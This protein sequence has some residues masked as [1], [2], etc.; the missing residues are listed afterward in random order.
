MSNIF[1]KQS[2]INNHP[3]RNNFDLS[4]QNHLTM[5][6]GNLYPV[7]CKEVVP[8]DSFRIKSAFGLKFMPMVFPVQSK[9]RAHMHFFYVRNKN[10]WDR[11]EDWISGLK[12]SADGVE[13]PYI[14]RAGSYFT[15]GSL[16]DYFNIP[17]TIAETFDD[18]TV[19]PHF[20]KTA[21]LI[22][23]RGALQMIE[24]G[25]SIPDNF[26]SLGEYPC[27]VSMAFNF[28]DGGVELPR[29]YSSFDS[30]LDTYSGKLCYLLD[31]IFET[32]SNSTL[33]V[34]FDGHSAENIDA[35][36]F[37]FALYKYELDGSW[38]CVD[39]H[40]AAPTDYNYDSDSGIH[41]FVYDAFQHGRYRIAVIPNDYLGSV[42]YS[43]STQLPFDPIISVSSVSLTHLVKSSIENAPST[44][45]A[46]DASASFDR[47]HINALP[48][49]AYES[50]CNVFYR[51]SVVDPFK[52]GGAVEY[53]K[54]ITNN[55]GGA[56]STTPIN[57]YQRNY[58]FDFLTSALPSPQQGIAPL[59]GLSALGEITVSDV[60][61]S[62]INATFELAED[63]S[64]TGKVA[65]H[66]PAAS[67][68]AKSYLSQAGM[69]LCGLSINDFRNVNALQQW[70]ETNIRKGYRYVDFIEGH[71]GKA[72]KYDVLDMPEFIGGFSRDVNISQII[73]SADMGVI[74]EKAGTLG[75]FAGIG[76]CFGQS[77][78]EISHYCDDYGFIIGILCVTPTPSYS[79]LLPKMYLKSNP[80]DYYFN[81][82]SQIGYQPITYEEVAP[83]SGYQYNLN[84]PLAQKP[85]TDTFGYQ[86]PNYDLV[87]SV[88]EVHGQFRTTLRDF[89]ISRYFAERPQLGRD[90][91]KIDNE[92]CSNIFSVTN[93]A[94]DNILG[95]VIF[96]VYAKRP[97]PRVVIPSLGR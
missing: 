65:I 95:Q 56:D 78:H 24:N 38:R 2:E 62:P 34:S 97:I 26:V 60:D 20:S 9:M 96:E 51:N 55:S 59:V 15:T 82:F 68:A 71:F 25:T 21:T 19:Y 63:S 64:F 93:P 42:I 70:L 45:F 79:Q 5:K 87:A 92:D 73:Q 29:N 48:F 54:Y 16:F 37:L 44:P 81:E 67:S 74:D 72:P 17:T 3:K 94:D 6:F 91:I 32:S 28:G 53:N 30:V 69:A 89:L 10:L 23:N 52:I 86:R 14:S 22:S 57:L 61:G 75:S 8:G 76:S 66:N 31:G 50:I 35:N 80:L 39:I 83:L 13:H 85:L 47:V 46:G 84:H 88:D 4:F 12:G 11:W 1:K 33:T 18:A 77:N 7:F 43:G 90:F 36:S 41:T 58:E 27:M 49:R 40:G